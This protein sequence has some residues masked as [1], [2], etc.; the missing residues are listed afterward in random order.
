MT[1]TAQTGDTGGRP[2]SGG[3]GPQDDGGQKV[4]PKTDRPIYQARI[5]QLSNLETAEVTVNGKT[6]RLWVMDTDAKRS[7]GMMYLED[8]DFKDDEGMVFAFRTEEPRKFWMRNTKVDLD[9]CY[10]DKNG[11]IL[12][13]YTMKSF[14]ETS[15]YSSAGPSQYV[16]ELKAGALKKHGI[17]DGMTFKIP[18]SVVSKDSGG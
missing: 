18:K 6:F 12:N 15:D 3:A 16:I 17:K 9:I 4:K 2:T 5:Y 11:K 7:E 14:D 13:T 10:C 1:G 8:Q